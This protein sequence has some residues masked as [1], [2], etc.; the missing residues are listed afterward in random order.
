[1]SHYK[2]FE[3]TFYTSEN[4][5]DRLVHQISTLL[6]T[7]EYSKR[8]ETEAYASASDC[9]SLHVYGDLYNP[10][11]FLDAL[12]G[13]DCEA[14]SVIREIDHEQESSGEYRK[15]ENDSWEYVDGKV[16]YFSEAE[17]KYIKELL[18]NELNRYPKKRK[19]FDS[20]LKQIG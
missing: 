17:C 10:E 6:D 19:E 12:E 3:C 1:M 4:Q 15:K 14:C 8:N 13:L 2:T 18:C 11:G 20:V 7:Y 16:Y 9:V 5:T